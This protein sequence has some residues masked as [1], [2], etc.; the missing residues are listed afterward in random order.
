[1]TVPGSPRREIP[2]RPQAVEDAL[3]LG[4][5][6]A[7]EAAITEAD[8]PGRGRQLA[9]TS[10]EVR[11]LVRGRTLPGSGRTDSRRKL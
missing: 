2:S 9:Q 11:A 8:G 4:G 5:L 1:M 7:L 6:L 3:F 10:E